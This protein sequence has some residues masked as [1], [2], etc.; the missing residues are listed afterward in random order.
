ATSVNIGVI[1]G[2]SPQQGGLVPHCQYFDKFGNAYGYD[3]YCFSGPLWA[4]DNHQF[5]C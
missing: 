2:G 3:K 5:L 4:L 1:G